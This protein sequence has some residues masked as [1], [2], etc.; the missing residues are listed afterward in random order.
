[1][2]KI[3]VIGWCSLLV[4]M[5]AMVAQARDTLTFQSLLDEMIDREASA[6]FPSPA[7]TCRQASSYDR[8][9]VSP[10]DPASWQANNDRS[11][12]IRSEENDGREE[13]VML[14]AEGP[15]CIV[16][17]WA[18]S[19]NPI[20]HIRVYLDGADKPVIDAPAKTLVG[21]NALVGPPL[22]KVRARGMNLYL[23]IPYA[24]SCK[25]TYDRPNF[26]KSRN[27]DDLLYYQINYRTYEKGAKV[28]SFS[29]RGFAAAKQRIARLQKQLLEPADA[30]PTDTE[31]LSAAPFK[32]LAGTSRVL[33]ID[34]PKAI[35]KISVRI[36]ADD[37][38]QASRTTVVSAKFD[39]VQ[40]IWC[41]SGDFFGSGVGVNP[42]K[43]WWR[44]VAKDGTMTCYWVMPFEKSAEMT[45]T[46]LGK[47]SV[48]ITSEFEV[49]PWEWDDRCMHFHTTWRQEYPIDTSRHHDWN[50]VTIDGQG[51]Y[52]GD[53]LVLNN[54]SPVWWGEG[55]EKIYFD[56]QKFPSHFGTGTEDYYGYAWCT[57]EFFESPFH[58]Q[59]RA[60]G[61]GNKGHV[62]NTRVRLLDG[63]PF[64]KDFRFDME[65]WHWR[66]CTIAYAA[67]THWYGR[68]G[69]K[70]NYGPMPEWAKVIVAEGPKPV[71]V[72][73]AIEGEGLKILEKTGGGTTEVQ[74]AP[75]HRWSRNQQV[76][77]RDGKP[78]DKLILALPVEKARKYKLSAALTKAVDY[79]IV[80]LSLDGKKL[81]APID[82]FN[83]GVVTKVYDLGT[84]GLTAGQHRLSA[85]ITGANPK[86]VK[87]H[88]FGIDY[89]KLVPAE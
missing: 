24:K 83:N 19:G 57:P 80:Q 62:T 86:A 67:T 22:S 38:E 26:H 52:M 21:G 42:Y 2:R 46:N 82:L 66:P 3:R 68:P 10:D 89:L 61:P 45:I 87:S 31:I 49:T 14:S 71:I 29:K 6:R 51:V 85:A 18:T 72:E 88:M 35:R 44:T 16:R 60:E 84:H 4:A 23:P 11:F 55:D 79:G 40:T 70:A 30:V 5:A 76:W 75:E 65:V 47:K 73:G 28:E 8:A 37:L 64:K 48:V 58:A 50:Y 63:I 12:F 77:W 13:W 69:A 39:G 36:E 20:G 1:M 15:G 33:E 56:G 53:S 59:P 9:S 7:Y 43:G 17:F 41:P 54:P 34:G 81:G 25:I 32:L 78:G 27:N 74:T